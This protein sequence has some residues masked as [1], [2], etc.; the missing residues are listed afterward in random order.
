MSSLS[1]YRLLHNWLNTRLGDASALRPSSAEVRRLALALDPTDLPPT[2]DADALFLHR[3]H[4][5]GDLFPHLS[6]LTSHD[7][8]DA[9]LTTGD[10]RA[11]ARALGWQDVKPLHLQKAAGL[12]A[13]APQ[14]DWPGLIAT[15]EAEFGGLEETV[16]PSVFQPRLALVNAMRPELLEELA[17][18]GAGLLVTGQM[19]RSALPRARELG[20]G[21]VALGHRRSELWGL[22]Q[23][24][25]ELRGA[26]PA[27]ACTV[28]GKA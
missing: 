18:Q 25:S 16:A 23:L 24:A 21:V 28:Y 5:L 19:R 26:F 3:S 27:L 7:G 6:V 4:R 2:L 20:L 10:N 12:L 11:L 9:A 8:F 13:T 1:S 15:L 22:R 14:H 17:A